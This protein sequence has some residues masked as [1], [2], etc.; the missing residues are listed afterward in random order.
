VI[1]EEEEVGVE[2]FLISRGEVEVYQQGK[3]SYF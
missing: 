3:N 2:M 1:V